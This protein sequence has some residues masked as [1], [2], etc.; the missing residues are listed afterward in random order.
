MNCVW[1][2]KELLG[3]LAEV[4][5]GGIVTHISTIQAIQDVT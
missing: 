1:E 3:I 4:S 2:M 5:I